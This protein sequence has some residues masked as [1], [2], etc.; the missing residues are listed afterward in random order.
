MD[1]DVLTRLRHVMA[2]LT[3][4][5]RDIFRLL[6]KYQL[7][8]L[9]EADVDVQSRVS[10]KIKNAKVSAPK[11]LDKTCEKYSHDTG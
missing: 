7:Q 4:N 8:T 10:K 2:S 1:V 3:Q 9:E 5:A 11:K 6:V